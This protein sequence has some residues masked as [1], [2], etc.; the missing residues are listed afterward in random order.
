MDRIERL[1]WYDSYM[2]L[3][4]EKKHA[5][6]DIDDLENPEKQLKRVIKFFD[7]LGADYAKNKLIVQT[8]ANISL[9]N[10]G[11]DSRLSQLKRE[12]RAGSAIEN[13]VRLQDDESIRTMLIYKDDEH[14][15]QL[16]Q[17][18]MFYIGVS[19]VK[20]NP[21]DKRMGSYK[22]IMEEA[23]DAILK[24]YPPSGEISLFKS[25]GVDYYIYYFE[26]LQECI[27]QRN[28]RSEFGE[29]CDKVRERCYNAR[30]MFNNYAQDIYVAGDIEKILL[31]ISNLEG[32]LIE[33]L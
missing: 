4:E 26:C 3:M 19:K 12:V 32:L 15:K 30:L 21:L 27:K 5:E 1:P 8:E 23:Y 7:N 24:R 31:E 16:I 18:L 17:Q 2:L 9:S 22:T 20:D 6:I 28:K 13:A 25:E 33:I 14:Y 10:K 11:K 29:L